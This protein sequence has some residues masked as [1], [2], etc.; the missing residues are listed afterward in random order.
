[1][2]PQSLQLKYQ[3]FLGRIAM[4]WREIVSR[5]SEAMQ[6]QR[7]CYGCCQAGLTVNRLERES[8]A[9]FL[10]QEGVRVAARAGGMPGHCEFLDGD[11][12]CTIFPVRPVICRTHGAPITFRSEDGEAMEADVCPLNFADAGIQD[13]PSGD[14]YNIDTVNTILAA[15]NQAYSPAEAT[16]RYP[17]SLAEF[18]LSKVT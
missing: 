6:C 16:T 3:E 9:G 4:K 15:L 2:S 12:G 7:G 17:L 10:N 18:N 13:L 8:I 5:H 1:M 11:G 14:Y